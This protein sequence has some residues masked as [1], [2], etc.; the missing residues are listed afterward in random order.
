MNV[1]EAKDFLV[2]QT[3]EQAALES[4]PLSDLEKRMMYFSESDDS[5]QNPIALNEEFEA[6]YN[7]D[8][9]EAKL[10]RL[11]RHAYSRTKKENPGQK[12]MWDE[13]IRELRKSDHYIL[14]MWDTHGSAERPAHDQL[15]LFGAAIAVAAGVVLVSIFFHHLA[16]RLPDEPV[17]RW[18]ARRLVFLVVVGAYFGWKY[19]KTR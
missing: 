18:V 6:Q 9:Y 11:L 1:R 3:A 4:V 7:S 13:A 10:A 19:F 14:A 15:K 8:E 17:V 2:N 12:R 5:C 16:L